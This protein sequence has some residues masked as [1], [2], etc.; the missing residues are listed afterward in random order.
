MGESMH[1]WLVV[2]KPEGITSAGVVSK[3]KK[4]LKPAKIGHG[5][6]L[7]PMATGILPLALG[8][9][10][11]AFH[12]VAM[13]EKVYS[14]TVKWGEA[15]STD[16]SEGEITHACDIRPGED[17]IRQLLPKF[18]GTILQRPPNV[19]A[20]K[21]D[22]Q[23]A[24]KRARE[25]QKIDIPLRP[26]DVFSLELV[27]ILDESRASFRVRC[28]KGT[29]VRSLARD[30]GEALGCYGHICRLR[31]ELVGKFTQKQAISLDSLKEIDYETALAAIK[32]IDMVLDDIPAISLEPQQV[33]RLI[34]GQVA[35]PLQAGIRFRESPV[36][37]CYRAEDGALFALGKPVGSM[38]QAIRVLNV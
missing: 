34:H 2:D 5:G 23:R 20:I 10:T 13:Q 6:T 9:A 15:T 27:E 28:G 35:T 7:D 8:E 22:G 11:K 12:Y 24:Y 17:E 37:R 19:S 1:G 30:M 36:V 3:V 31:R 29:Y 38:I 14:F 21:V 16:D 26:V 4:L 18:I 33:K 32:P 25:G